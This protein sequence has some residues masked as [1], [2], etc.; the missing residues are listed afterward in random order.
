MFILDIQSK[1]EPDLNEMT[2]AYMR[3]LKLDLRY[4]QLPLSRCRSQLHHVDRSS[5]VQPPLSASLTTSLFAAISRTTEVLLP[6]S[7]ET[8]SGN[9]M[10]L[11]SGTFTSPSRASW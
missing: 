6:T 4:E 8:D 11:R 2:A 10:Y 3:I 5:P 1:L 7:A 9:W